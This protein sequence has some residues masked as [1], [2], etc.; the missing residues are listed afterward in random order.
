[1][2]MVRSPVR[3]AFCPKMKLERPAVQVCSA[4]TSVKSAPSRAMRSMLEKMKK[5]YTA[6]GKKWKVHLDG[7]N[8][9]PYLT[10]KAKNGPRESY[11]Y[12]GMDGSLN[13]VRWK[14]FKAHF[15]YQIGP[16]NPFSGSY[17]VTPFA[18]MIFNLRADPFE[19][20]QYESGAWENF[21]IDQMW[22]FVPLQQAIAGFLSTIPDYPFQ[23][24]S[25]L[26]ASNINYDLFRRAD[27]MQRLK[28]LQ[29][30]LEELGLGA[31]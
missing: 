17:M 4:Y 23:M 25:S 14:N 24:G 1:M 30:Q 11:L 31:H 29:K 18:P 28:G 15:N 10:G 16:P 3:N 5:G 20:A 2:P 7:Y 27:A 22:L 13:A 8:F 12:F 26:S 9:L 19:R 21:A 6:N